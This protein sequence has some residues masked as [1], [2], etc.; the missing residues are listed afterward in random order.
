MGNKTLPCRMRGPDLATLKRVGWFDPNTRGNFPVKYYFHGDNLQIQM[1]GNI[2][3]QPNYV[4]C[5]M[6]Q[7]NTLLL[8]IS[9][10]LPGHFHIPADVHANEAH[11]PSVGE[12]RQNIP[13][14]QVK[15]HY[16]EDKK[17]YDSLVSDGCSYSENLKP[18][19]M[20]ANKRAKSL[21]VSLPDLPEEY[22]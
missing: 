18:A 17:L 8:L 3:Q 15:E 11:W 21:R 9:A 20:D 14:E 5:A 1:L 2:M 13:W 4:V 6:P 22:W 19:V 16:T 12:F 7:R 10:M